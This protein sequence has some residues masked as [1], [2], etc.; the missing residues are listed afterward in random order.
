MGRVDFYALWS[1]LDTPRQMISK[2]GQMSYQLPIP[3]PL[4]K[5]LVLFSLG[6]WSSYTIDTRISA[7]LVTG[8]IQP[9]Y[10]GNL[11]S[12]CRCLVWEGEWSVD[13]TEECVKMATQGI[14]AKLLLTVLKSSGFS[15][16]TPAKRQL[17]VGL[18]SSP[19]LSESTI[20]P[21]RL[22]DMALEDKVQCSE[23]AQ[24]ATE[25]ILKDSP[26]LKKAQ[27]V[28]PPHTKEDEAGGLETLRKMSCKQRNPRRLRFGMKGSQGG[29]PVCPSVRTGH[30]VC[31]CDP[32]TAIL[33]GGEGTNEQPCEDSL[34][35]MELDSEFWVP[36]DGI[37]QGSSPLSSRGHSATFDPETKKVY[38]YGGMRES[39]RFSCIYVLDTLDWKWTLVT[40][41]GKVP[42]LSFHSAIMYQRELY[43]F[44]GLC[45]QPGTELGSSTNSLYI[46]NPEYKIWYQP[47]V[48]GVLPLA[49]FGHT[50]TLLGK[51][52]VIF[53]GKRTPS[54]IYLND[55]H[56]LDLGYME[57]APVSLSVNAEKPAA[58]CFHA[59]MPVSD[60]RVLIHGGSSSLGT[61]GDV[62]L[63]SLENL[64]WS[65]I[66]FGD[67]P[68][69][70]RYGHTLL[71]LTSS[72]LTDSDK[73]KRKG[74]SICSIMI[75]GGS[76][77][78]GN[79]YCDNPKFLIDVTP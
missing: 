35:K 11:S 53:G 62:F 76:N 79:Y 15:S 5:Q 25:E 47:M 9:Q 20:V 48:K 23:V 30:S 70:S 72:H 57:Y 45:P 52:V 18:P 33:I 16:S 31:L 34:W 29:S 56:I 40:A 43:V 64:S 68:E 8:G 78:S 55:V 61:L 12:D 69:H 41:M 71:N 58:R 37:C 65:P 2:R 19:L 6:D 3:L 77:V 51:H 10:L 60:D 32:E 44:G 49:R 24:Q 13:I 7:Q 39:R 21:V 67:A 63:F 54:P 17:R 27:S 73:E 14:P 66:K 75:I 22:L 36:M 42:T 59:A 74:R 50:A 28:L 46:F 4:P 38:V 1:V 26:P